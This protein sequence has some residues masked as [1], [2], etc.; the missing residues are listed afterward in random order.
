[1]RILHVTECFSAGTGRAIEAR[2]V[3]TPAL[4]HHVLWTGDEGP[5]ETLPWAGIRQLPTRGHLARVRSVAEVVQEVR[6]DVVHAHSSWAGVYTRVKS[7]PVPVVY[8]PHCFKFDDPNTAW[9]IKSLYLAA[10][11][12]QARRTLRFGALTPHELRLVRSLDP[13]ADGVIIPNVPSV[14]TVA[15]RWSADRADSAPF[16][17]AMIGRIVPQKDPNLYAR[18]A[19]AV[20][21]LDTAAELV[22]IGDG[23]SGLRRT[24]E[25]A[26]V[27]VTGWL[28]STSLAQELDRTAVYLHTAAYEGF[29]LGVLDAAA[30]DVPIVTRRIP[31]LEGFSL[32]TDTG[33]QE[34]A[35]LVVDVQRD[36]N[37]RE[38][39]SQANR[40]LLNM[41][42][43]EN[44][45]SALYSLYGV[46][47]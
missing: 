31:A 13:K 23:D 42:N 43:P 38:K 41:M 10:E 35:R 4:E 15:E 26:G 1:M 22:W 16:R 2:V 12:W 19:V 8:E 5:D 36:P 45:Q 34:L 14:P 21:Q 37:L 9:P 27:R 29:P 17:V 40:E 44:L 46:V 25:E 6:P 33:V 30:R 32:L 24:L 7:L 28:D 39:A 47:E 20:R 18:V 11:R 3:A